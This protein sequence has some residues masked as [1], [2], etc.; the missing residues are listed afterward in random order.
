MYKITRR[1]VRDIKPDLICLATYKTTISKHKIN[2]TFDLFCF[3]KEKAFHGVKPAILQQHPRR[4]P[5][6]LETHLARLWAMDP[7]MTPVCMNINK[8]A[9]GSFKMGQ[10]WAETANAIP[11]SC[12]ENSH[13]LRMQKGEQMKAKL[14]CFSKEAC[15]GCCTT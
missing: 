15:L 13:G 12:W 10:N 7:S 9:E 6:E 1:K 2:F 8:G 14:Q 11:C 4:R 3:A 5:C